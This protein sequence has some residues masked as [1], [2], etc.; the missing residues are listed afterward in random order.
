MRALAILSLI[1]CSGGSDS[2][3]A[4]GATALAFCE[5][6]TQHR[7]DPDV[8]TELEQWPDDHWSVD[9]PSSPT[10]Q[11]I[12]LEGAPWAGAL[13]DTL[14]PL[15]EQLEG[16][17]GFATQGR[18]VMR[19]SAPLAEPQLD[20]DAS[21][22]SDALQLF[23]LS[24]L[25]PARVPYSATLEDGG[26]QLRV[27]PLR[28]LR[29]GARHALIATRSLSAGDGGCVAPSPRL[30][31]LLRGSGEPRLVSLHISLMSYL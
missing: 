9:D 10:G 12:V 5:G 8:S 19:F 24:E 23:D 29:P 13:S 16:G 26:T 14:A 21:L 6:P 3:P 20:A 27:Q 25:P 1:A 17:T 15:A 30:E 18:I 11:R 4:G 22:V 28:P 2:S 7:Y 31:Q